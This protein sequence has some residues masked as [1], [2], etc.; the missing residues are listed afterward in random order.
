MELPA[1]GRYL[2]SHSSWPLNCTHS[3]WCNVSPMHQLSCHSCN[4][5]VLRQVLHL[6]QLQPSFLS[7]QLCPLW[8][9]KT[10]GKDLRD[11]SKQQKNRHRLMNTEHIYIHQNNKKKEL[12]STFP[13]GKWVF[14]FPCLGFSSTTGS[15]GLVYKRDVWGILF[16][17]ETSG[18]TCT[19]TFWENLT[20]VTQ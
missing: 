18:A 11:R 6:L 9:N 14:C 2:P 5:T 13:V 15:P 10:T 8:L 20:K 7:S 12:K 19:C 3:P 16:D 1:Y 4:N 17:C